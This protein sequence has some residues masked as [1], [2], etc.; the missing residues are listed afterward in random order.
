MIVF[1]VNEIIMNI[2]VQIQIASLDDHNPFPI[3]EATTPSPQDI[4]DNKEV[5][6][7]TT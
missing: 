1:S 7:K 6:A 4:K 3:M 2:K 5:K